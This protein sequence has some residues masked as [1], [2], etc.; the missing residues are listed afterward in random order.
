M[1]GHATLWIEHVGK[2]HAITLK[3]IYPVE[4]VASALI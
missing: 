4:K 1:D 2:V 3:N